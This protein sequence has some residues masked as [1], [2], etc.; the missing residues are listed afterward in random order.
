MKTSWDYNQNLFED[1]IEFVKSKKGDPK[2]PESLCHFDQIHA[3]GFRATIN[4]LN[5]IDIK[6]NQILLDLGGGIGGSARILATKFRCKIINLDYSLNYCITGKK[7][8]KLCNI[9]NI[10]FINGDATQIPLKNNL[11]SHILLQ[12]LNMNIKDKD[13]LL[14]ECKRVSTNDGIIVFHEWFIKDNLNIDKLKYP[15]PWSDNPEFSY[16]ITYKDFLERASKYGYEILHTED[17]SLVALK[18]YKKIYEERNFSNPIFS[19]RNPEQIFE[20]I[21]SALESNL[22]EVYTGILKLNK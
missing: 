2:N 5:L 6:E 19:K 3:G 10:F 13:T 15:L 22:L 20:N 18:F 9:E 4:L 21:I 11:I 14:E 7:L 12:H 17:D 1:L 8:S 16:L